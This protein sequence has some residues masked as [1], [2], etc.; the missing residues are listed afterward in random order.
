MTHIL[1]RKPLSDQE[2]HDIYAS[3]QTMYPAPLPYERLQSWVTACPDLSLSY[4]TPLKDTQS[5]L[6][7]GVAIVLPVRAQ[8]WRDLVVGK[9]KEIDVDAMTMLSDQAGVEL[10]LHI[11]HIEKFDSW[12]QLGDGYDSKL[13]PFAEYVTADMA[14]MIEV[15]GWKVLGFS[16][17]HYTYQL[18]LLLLTSLQ[19]S[20]PLQQVSSVSSE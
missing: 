12:Q 14:K 5:L 17:N 7:V 19:P 2:L 1:R 10:G 6:V 4:S 18:Y 9:L 20:L 16:G 11:F 13:R 3:D 15:R 8:Y